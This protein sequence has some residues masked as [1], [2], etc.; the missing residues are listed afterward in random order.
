MKCLFQIADSELY[1]FSFSPIDSRMYVL[2]AKDQALI[3]DPCV[4]TMALELL[5]SRNVRDVLVLPTHEHYDHISGVN[6][7]KENFRCNVIASEQCAEN[8]TNPRYN[9]SAY[10]EAMFVFADD[11]VKKKVTEQNIQPYICKADEVFSG[12]RCL[13]WQSRKVEIYQTPGHSKGSVCIVI[14]GVYVFTGDSL[15][16]GEPTITR[17]PGGSKREFAENT[18]MFLKNLPQSSIIFPGHGGPGYIMEFSLD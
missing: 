3:I 17:L 6:W 18:R 1:S 13:T 4:D 11:E 7:I 16:R 5:K 12:Y 2:I 9:L 14:D 10:F 15:I 8:M